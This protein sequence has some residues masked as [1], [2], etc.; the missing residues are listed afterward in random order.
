MEIDEISTAE[1]GTLVDALDIPI[2]SKSSFLE[3]NRNK[4]DTIHY[5]L[6]KDKHNRFALAVGERLNEW[7]APFSAPFS[8]VVELRKDNTLETL[9]A[10]INLLVKFVKDRDGKTINLFVPPNIYDEH[11][12]AKEM[13]ALLGNG[14]CVKYEDINY[15]VELDQIAIDTYESMIHH[16]A[17]KNLRIALKSGLMFKRCNNDYEIEESYKIIAVNRESKGYPLRMTKEQVLD[18]LRIVNHDCF[19]VKLG[20]ISI[21]SAIVYQITNQIA[22]VIYWGDIPG[23]TNYKPVNYIAYNL[24]CYY[25]D[26]GFRLLD[27]GPST[28]NGI[29]NY[30][31]CD[32]KES[33]GCI[34]NAKLRYLRIV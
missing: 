17:R 12:N 14:F 6:G 4:V 11:F 20:E 33:I 16:N 10:F 34:P 23:F 29:P 8:N 22:H 27:I 7:M 2:Y 25:K 19:L 15:S 31:L 13:N 30:G 21:A 5:L 18:T 26:L 1:Y 3:L 9:Y 32:F 24:I 28:E